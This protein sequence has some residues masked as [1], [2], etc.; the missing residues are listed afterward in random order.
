M[1]DPGDQFVEVQG[2][3]TRFWKVGNEGSPIVLL[4]GIGCSVLEWRNNIDVLAASHRVYALDMLGD[5][6]TGKPEGDHYSI[7]NL[8]RFTLDF[9][10]SQGEDRA[11]FIGNSLGGRIALECAR[12]ARDILGANGVA[13]EYP[14]FRHMANLESVKTYEGTH[15]IHTLIIG[16]SVTGIDAF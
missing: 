12:L 8:A 13:D 2:V 6:K 5:G 1:A 7:G 11:H 3:K 9:L 14:I 10:S 4:A 16:Q 15:D